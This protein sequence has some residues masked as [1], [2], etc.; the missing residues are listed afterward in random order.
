MK[1]KTLNNAFPIVAASMGNRFGVAVSVGGE[2]AY[3]DGKAINLPAYNGDDPG[4][5]EVAWGFLAHEA[6]H[7]RFTD[8]EQFKAAATSPLRKT[9]VNLLEDVRVESAIQAVYPG[10]RSSLEKTVGHLVETGLFQAPSDTEPH[11]ARVLGEFLLFRLRHDV[12][13]QT[14]LADYADKAERLLESVF[15]PGAVTRLAGLL[16]EVPRLDSTRAAVR[17]ADRILRMIQEEQEKEAEMNRQQSRPP[18]QDGGSDSDSDGGQ[19]SPG[20]GGQPSGDPSGNPSGDDSQPGQAGQPDGDPSDGRAAHGS[21]GH[22]PGQAARTLASVLSA[23]SGDVPA[24]LGDAVRTLLDAQPAGSYD[25]LVRLP[26]VEDALRD[27]AAGKAMLKKVSAESG[28]IRLALHGFVQSSRND[29]AVHKRAG[30]R[31][32]GRKLARLALGDS[33]VFLRSAAQQAPNTA[34]HIVVD[35]SPSMAR[36]SGNG[37]ASIDVA[38][39][40]AM[41]LALALE[42]IPGVNPAVTRFPTSSQGGVA[43]IMPHGGKIRAHAGAFRPHTIG[44]TPLDQALWHAAATLLDTREPRKVILVLTDGQ[45]DD[46][47]E[48]LP[49]TLGMIRRCEASGMELVGVGIFLDASQLFRK[50]VK[51]DDLNDLRPALFGIGKALLAA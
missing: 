25:P 13:G 44:G 10:A 34:I 6:A 15:P 27:D 28:R 31:V 21:D 23:G 40:A 3:T 5:K 11:P 32:D 20:D 2:G 42:G 22:D 50:S 16:A 30:N 1:N 24:D 26:A 8:F 12:N 43:R 37:V 4:Y 41:A 19:P 46:I 9:L 38:M 29:L 18:R 51:I 7:V 35:G 14:M 48:G 49:S 39:E 45:P 47:G 36:R 17:L 33:R